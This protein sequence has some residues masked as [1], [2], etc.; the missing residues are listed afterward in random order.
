MPMSE[1]TLKT[2]KDNV[3]HCVSDDDFGCRNGSITYLLH[4]IPLHLGLISE[5]FSFLYFIFICLHK[6]Q[7]K[8]DYTYL[9]LGLWLRLGRLIYFS[10]LCFT[11]FFKLVRRL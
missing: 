4:Y 10:N 9:N 5:R 1:C 11:L 7:P 8:A 3:P 6:L 2:D